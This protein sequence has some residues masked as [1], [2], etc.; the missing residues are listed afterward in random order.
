[1]EE[2]LRDVGPNNLKACEILLREMYIRAS[3][4]RFVVMEAYVLFMGKSPGGLERGIKK[5]TEVLKQ[6]QDYIPA[7]LALA[8]GKLV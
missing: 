4:Q 8:V 3:Y 7:M 5:L 2:G 1:M 6:R